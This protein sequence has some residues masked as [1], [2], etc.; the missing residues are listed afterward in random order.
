M[1]PIYIKKNYTTSKLW[2]KSIEEREDLVVID[3]NN[4]LAGVVNTTINCIDAILKSYEMLRKEIL[5]IR[6]VDE[7]K[8]TE[9][10]SRK[11]QGKKHKN[12]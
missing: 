7:L 2:N 5:G 12:K 4:S 1:I 3:G 8:V 11:K 10:K 9:F 6:D